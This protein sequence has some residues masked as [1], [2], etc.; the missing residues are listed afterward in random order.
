MTLMP[1]TEYGEQ[2]MEKIHSMITTILEQGHT[3]S[4]IAILCRSKSTIQEIAR[5]FGE[6]YP[7]V[8][9]ISDEAFRLDASVAVNTLISALRYVSNPESSI[10]RAYLKQVGILAPVERTREQLLTMPL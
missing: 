2:I 4:S 3:P 7:S 1:S 6:N 9:L 10:D 8:P 5:F